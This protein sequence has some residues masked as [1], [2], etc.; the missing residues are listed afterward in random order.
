M[1]KY[2]PMS[3]QN[4]SRGWITDDTFHKNFAEE[5]IRALHFFDVARDE[6]DQ[7]SQMISKFSTETYNW[8]TVSNKWKF[9]IGALTNKIPEIFFDPS[10]IDKILFEDVYIKNE[11]RIGELKETDVVIDIGAHRGYFSKL[12]LDNGSKNVICFEPERENYNFLQKNLQEYSGAKYFNLAV[13]GPDTKEIDL[14]SYYT[15]YNTGLN[16]AYK[17]KGD[18]FK[19]YEIQKVKCITLDD[20]L[21]KLEKV[22]LIKIDTEGSEFEIIMNSKLLNKVDE[23]VGE[24]HNGMHQKF[25]LIDLKEFLEK[26][27]FEFSFEYDTTGEN[28]E[29]S[30]LFFAKNLIS[31]HYK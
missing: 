10:S 4:T 17:L 20:I 14:Y 9:F 22:R 30:G 29:V 26:N 27:N 8:K 2:I 3:G 25:N 31:E 5:V 12:C 16:T 19:E 13:H 7:V 21:N 24:F 15:K 28:K 6:Y 18:I 1:G 11:Y 23:I